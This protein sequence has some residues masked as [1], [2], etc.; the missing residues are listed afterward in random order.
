MS[1]MMAWQLSY[2][3]INYFLLVKIHTWSQDININYKTLASM[4]ILHTNNV[5]T[6]TVSVNL[7]DIIHLKHVHTLSV[8]KMMAW[9]PSHWNINYNACE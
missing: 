2:T 3:N 6:Q 4:G 1:E 9:Q 8:R 7:L 5:H